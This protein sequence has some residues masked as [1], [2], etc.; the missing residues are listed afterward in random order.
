MAEEFLVMNHGETVSSRIEVSREK[1]EEVKKVLEP[2]GI[3]FRS[4]RR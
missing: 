1:F 3:T 2:L 4:P